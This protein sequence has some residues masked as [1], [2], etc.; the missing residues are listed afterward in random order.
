MLNE[1]NKVSTIKKNREPVSKNVYPTFRVPIATKSPM[2]ALYN[3]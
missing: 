2:I 3:I 1:I